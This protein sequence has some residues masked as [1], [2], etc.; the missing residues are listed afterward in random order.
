MFTVQLLLIIFLFSIF[1]GLDDFVLFRLCLQM[2]IDHSKAEQ[3]ECPYIDDRY[4]C[5]GVLQHR[6]IK[7][8]P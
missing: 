5:T 1:G 7:K 6:E 2:T 4:S 3:V 8:V